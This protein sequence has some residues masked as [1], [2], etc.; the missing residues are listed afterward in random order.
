MVFCPSICYFFIVRSIYIRL[1]LWSL[2]VWFTLFIFAVELPVFPQAV[3]AY[4]LPGAHVCLS[5]SCDNNYPLLKGIKLN[6]QDPLKLEFIIDP[7]GAASLSREDADRLISYFLACLTMPEDHMW[8]NLSP[9]EKNRV[10]PS[11]LG[12]TGLG[13]DLLGE[14]YILKQVASSLTHPDSELGKKYWRQLYDKVYALTGDKKAVLNAFNKVWIIPQQ[15]KAYQGDDFVYIDEASLQALQENDYLAM[16]KNFQKNQSAAALAASKAMQEL[17]LPQIGQDINNGKNFIKLRQIYYAFILATWFKRALKDSIYRY[18]INKEKIKGIDLSDKKVSAKVYGLYLESFSKGLYNYVKKERQG[19]SC[20]RRQYVSGGIR[21]TGFEHKPGAV[22]WS[23]MADNPQEFARRVDRGR[24]Y[25]VEAAVGPYHLSGMA[26][27]QLTLK[28]EQTLKL[29]LTQSLRLTSETLWKSV[30][31]IIPT[32]WERAA[33]RG[34]VR[35]YNKHGLNFEYLVLAPGDYQKGSALDNILEVSGGGFA[36]YCLKTKRFYL[37]VGSDY[38]PEEFVEYVAVHERG[39]ELFSGSSDEPAHTLATKLEFATAVKD[40]RLKEYM[41]FL[42]AHHLLK[43]ANVFTVMAGSDAFIPERV[44]DSQAFIRA[45]DVI[46]QSSE[47][48]AV[49]DEIDGFVWPVVLRR[50]LERFETA[51]NGAAKLLGD[52]FKTIAAEV[53]AWQSSGP[54]SFYEL[55]EKINV[56]IDKIVERI[57]QKGNSE[58]LYWLRIKSAT[59]DAAIAVGDKLAVARNRHAE[60]VKNM[61]VVRA[62]QAAHSRGVENAKTLEEIATAAEP[63]AERAVAAENVQIDGLR[64]QKFICWGVDF[65]KIRLAVDP[66]S[67]MRESGM[68]RVPS[69]T[70]AILDFIFERQRIFIEG[71]GFLN[72]KPLSIGDIARHFNIDE[73]QVRAALSEIS[74]QALD[75]GYDLRFLV[76]GDDLQYFVVAYQLHNLGYLDDS[77][78]QAQAQVKRNI[79][80]KFRERWHHNFGPLDETTFDQYLERY[81]KERHLFETKASDVTDDS[82]DEAGDVPAERTIAGVAGNNR[83]LGGIALSEKLLAMNVR[84]K[85]FNLPAAVLVGIR[86]ATGLEA[87]ILFIKKGVDF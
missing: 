68:P 53:E 76:P 50:E 10:I 6:H 77:D 83:D 72:L 46:E 20:V 21:F 61:Y 51:N 70:E 87:R 1:R 66:D 35:T 22:L 55:L 81:K 52:T 71:A 15:A 26:G 23:N 44:R 59:H 45:S 32:V 7:Q 29:E 64:A 41:A 80:Y 36:H 4:N 60:V 18:Y 42:K 49:F 38:F 82:L 54:G 30:D 28:H 56:R 13:R 5:L 75:G 24:L 84:G 14:D 85:V 19:L 65:D 43:F 37:V 47:F 8:V 79:L 63:E 17:I 57:Q 33:A 48:L 16:V 12:R 40:G 67:S 69:L 11:R 62:I 2:V 74:A 25:A 78:Q 31:K 27:L 39:E 9:Y 58:K 86:H 34:K 73:D 3:P